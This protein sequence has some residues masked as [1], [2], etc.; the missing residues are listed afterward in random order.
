[1]EYGGRNS[2]VRIPSRLAKRFSVRLSSS[3]M[4]L[5]EI[6]RGPLRIGT[7]VEGDR[8]LLGSGAIAGDAIGLGQVL[9]DL[10]GNETGGGIQHY[11]AL[12]VGRARF[13]AQNF[14]LAFHVDVLAGRNVFQLVGRGGLVG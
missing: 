8:D 13:D 6:S 12:A 7:V 10:V 11:V 1:M 5:L 9:K 2:I 3:L 14:A 4:W